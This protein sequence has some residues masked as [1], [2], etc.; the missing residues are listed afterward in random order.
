MRYFF[1]NLFLLPLLST[2]ISFAQKSEIGFGLGT[3]NYTGDL[4]RTYDFASS[5]PAGTV[6]YKSN[7][8]RII[9][10]RVGITAGKIG[11]SDVRRPMDALAANRKLSFNL[12]LLEASTVMEYH[13]LNWRDDKTMV[14]YSPY[15]FAGFGIF[16]LSGTNE[17]PA[18]YSNVQPM[19]PFGVGIKYVLNPKWYIGLEF[20]MRKTFFDYLDNVSGKDD[21]IKDY[22]FGN[23]NDN[24]HYY[25]LGLTLTRTFYSIPCPTNPYH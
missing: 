17:K 15:L 24:D 22:Q 3:F 9:S 11:A 19:I 7:L 14:R 13:F 10:F 5:K 4:V 6:Y 18:E 16:A 2:S 23:P 25:F 1:L 8:S 20:G 21:T 12:F